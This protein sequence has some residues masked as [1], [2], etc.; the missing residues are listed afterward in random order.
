M[1]ICAGRWLEAQ[2]KP[3]ALAASPPCQIH[4]I[5]ILAVIGKSCIPLDR[6]EKRTGESFV[7]AG[8]IKLGG[9]QHDGSGCQ[10]RFAE[11]AAGRLCSSG[12]A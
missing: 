4:A 1:H 3:S 10:Q 8:Q 11:P 5:G 9:A 2:R 6:Q 7:C 12:P